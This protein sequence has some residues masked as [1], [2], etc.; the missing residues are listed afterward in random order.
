MAKNN[1]NDFI[2]YLIKEAQNKSI[3][4][5]S[6]QGEYLARQTLSNIRA[7]ETSD[8]NMIRVLNRIAELYRQGVDIS[9]VRMF[10]CSGL[11][12][13]FFLSRELIKSDTTA[14]GLLHMC[15]KIP[16]DSAQPG[17]LVFVLNSR[18]EAT[19]VGY[20][21][22]SAGTVVEARG[23]DYGVQKYAKGLGSKW[24]CAGHPSFWE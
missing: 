3:Y 12:V 21:V 4:V 17:D 20:V 7:M 19:H 23:R 14:N 16:L 15:E 10:D 2:Q 6:G 22:D 13:K 8:A 18:K 1:K 24:T 11:G 5:W 9:K